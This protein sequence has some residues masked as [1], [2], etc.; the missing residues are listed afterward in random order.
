MSFRNAFTSSALGM[1]PAPVSEPLAGLRGKGIWGASGAIVAA[2]AI[3]NTDTIVKRSVN[4]IAASTLSAGDTFRFNIAGS[5]A[6]GGAD[7]G[8]FRV[9]WGTAGTT[10]D[11]DIQSFSITAAAGTAAFNAQ[12]VVVVRAVVAGVGGSTCSGSISIVNASATVGIK[13]INAFSL[14]GSATTFDS[15][16]ADNYISLSYISGNAGTTTTFEQ[17]TIEHV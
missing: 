5:C 4:K 14:A 6:A 3:A 13:A 1:V 8:I 16:T 9:R 10:A 17:C 2:A 7:V 15:T 12:I 11:T